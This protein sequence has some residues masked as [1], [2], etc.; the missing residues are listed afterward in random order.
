MVVVPK[1]VDVE[2]A[3]VS[4]VGA[5][6]GF[7]IAEPSVF[8]AFFDGEVDDGFFFAVIDAGY[9][10]QIAFSVYDLKFVHHAHG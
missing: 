2:R 10:S 5:D 3:H 8:H 1:A 7:G 4:A 9:T 6:T